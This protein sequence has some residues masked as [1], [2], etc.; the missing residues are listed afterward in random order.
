MNLEI[1]GMRNIYQIILIK[2]LSWK[3][4]YYLKCVVTVW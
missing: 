3:Q 4:Y 2:N 1:I